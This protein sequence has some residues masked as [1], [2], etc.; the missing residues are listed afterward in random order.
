LLG[1]GQRPRAKATR[2][3]AFAGIVSIFL[4]VG[5]AT[6]GFPR[7]CQSAQSTFTKSLKL[8]L[9]PAAKVLDLK[10]RVQFHPL[11]WWK[12]LW[13]SCRCTAKVQQFLK[14]S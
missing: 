14:L 4:R 2:S 11:K 5:V 7:T 1:A 8:G 13:I 9:S 6:P 3:L 12:T 10:I